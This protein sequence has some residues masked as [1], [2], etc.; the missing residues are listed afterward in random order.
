MNNTAEK[1]EHKASDKPTELGW[2]PKDWKLST[3]GKS[4]IIDNNLRYP[5][6][7][8]ERAKIKGEYPYYG[9]T[10]ILDYINE[11]RIDG[12]YAL[13][14]EDGDHFL[15][16]KNLAM[17]LL[18]EGKFNVNN[19]AHLIRGGENSITEWFYYFYMHREITP[20]LTRQG[21][22]RYKLTKQALLQ[23]PIALPSIKEQKK[24]AQ[25]LISWDKAIKSA[26]KLIET[27]QKRKKALTQ[28]LLTGKLR[29]TAF[30]GQKVNVVKLK[31]YLKESS[32]K[33][34]KNQIQNVLSVTNSRGFINQDEQFERS[35][36]S[37]DLKGYKIVKKGQFAYNPSRINV[38][39]IDLLK[40][41][42]TGIVSP[43]YVIFETKEDEL[44]NEYLKHFFKT[45]NFFEQMKAFTQGGVR[46]SL[47][48]K[49]L[50]MMKMFIP[51]IEEQKKIVVVLNSCDREIE[52][53]KQK[54]N[55]LNEQKK[56]L[57]QKL[58][59][60]KIRVKVDREVV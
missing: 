14:G 55:K 33:N 42:D 41:F 4:F 51:S 13:I 54:L 16:F 20:F 38:G 21:V 7:A 49:G 35:V 52:I 59:T 36:A 56:G 27:K 15:K 11:Y 50:S 39:S 34:N 5:I 23:M 25:I 10:K 8:E 60:G 1:T 43:I 57:M 29:F 37:K 45:Y 9:P 18:P 47:S 58:L 19:H 46:D 24:I 31:D 12:K 44:L 17:T 22:G 32:I 28:R 48:F 26:E 6:S 2:I 30:A 40:T 53:L 3:I